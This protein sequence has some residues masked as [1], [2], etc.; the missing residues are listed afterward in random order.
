[1]RHEAK[2]KVQFKTVFGLV[3]LSTQTLSTQNGTKYVFYFQTTF[4]IYTEN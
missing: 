4:E 2:F 3:S 1:M